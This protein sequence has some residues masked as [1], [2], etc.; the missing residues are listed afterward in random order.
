MKGAGFYSWDFLLNL[1]C[2]FDDFACLVNFCEN[3]KDDK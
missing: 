2:N 3:E 1:A